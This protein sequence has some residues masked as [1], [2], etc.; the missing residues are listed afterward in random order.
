MFLLIP[1]SSCCIVSEIQ[2]SCNRIVWL[3]EKEERE[4]KKKIALPFIPL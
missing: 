3:A 4:R 2:S 1:P